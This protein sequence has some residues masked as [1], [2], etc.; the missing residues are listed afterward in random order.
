MCPVEYTPIAGEWA[1]QGRPRQTL[2]NAMWKKRNHLCNAVIAADDDK[3][4]CREICLA[5]LSH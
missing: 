4:K 2:L 5:V 1:H 3:E